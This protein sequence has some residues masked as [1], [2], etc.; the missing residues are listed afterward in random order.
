MNKVKLFTLIAAVTFSAS[1]VA[2]IPGDGN[3]GEW[4]QM[5]ERCEA[6]GQGSYLGMTCSQIYYTWQDCQRNNS[7]S[8]DL[9]LG[10][11]D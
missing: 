2:K 10:K 6:K 3:C 7:R 9:V 4:L 8:A 11:N 5:L 1:S